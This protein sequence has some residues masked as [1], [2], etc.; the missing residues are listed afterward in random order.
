MFAGMVKL[1]LKTNYQRYEEPFTTAGEGLFLGVLF[2]I[3]GIIGLLSLR[4]T[5]Y[6]KI[7][8]FL[9]LSIFCS[10]FG[11]ILIITTL[12]LM[13]RALYKGY[14]PALI[15]HWT[16]MLIGIIESI[17]GIVSSSF[18]CHACCGCCVTGN[19]AS[20][21]GNSVVYIP[22]ANETDTSKP[23]VVHLNM[24]DIS[25]LPAG[26]NE[27]ATNAEDADNNGKYARFK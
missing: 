1:L 7:T 2:L 23:R 18:S 16:L 8:A 26:D 13:N 10:L 21:P 6:C 11:V 24:A 14:T 5:T 22:N 17:L 3:T 12:I 4:R 19:Q 25:K 20:G 9:V 15:C 27:D